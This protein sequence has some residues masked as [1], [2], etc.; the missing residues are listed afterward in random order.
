MISYNF[1][2]R[3]KIFFFR[4][5]FKTFFSKKFKHFG[6][7][8]RLI[9]PDS[10]QGENNISLSNNVFVNVG[11]WFLSLKNGKIVIEENTYIGRNSHIVALQSVKI[12]KN[13]LVA[14]KVYIA[15]NL[16]EYEDINTPIKEQ[17]VKF[18][19]SV[20]IKDN[21]WIGEN[22]SIIGANIGKNV[23]IGANSVINK[24]IPDYSV[25]VGAPAKVI[26]QYNF[27]NKEWQKI[28][29]S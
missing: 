12:G 4:I 11:A 22:V 2:K 10:I 18:I 1:F 3:V 17:P 7:G 29:V 6:K 5:F 19:G 16:H 14:D 25:A 23:V 21:S 9:Y 20:E 27:Q 26:K 8:V 28:D 15:D 13:V 24:D